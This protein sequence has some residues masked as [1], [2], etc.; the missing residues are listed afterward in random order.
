MSGRSRREGVAFGLK[1]GKRLEVRGSS[2]AI[3]Q[4]GIFYFRNGN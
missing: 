4:K 3:S 1:G 2:Q